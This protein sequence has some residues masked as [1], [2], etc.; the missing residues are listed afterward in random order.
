M[1]SF[2]K[3]YYRL[4]IIVGKIGLLNYPLFF[5]QEDKLSIELKELFKEWERRTSLALIPFYQER[6]KFMEEE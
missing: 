1:H 4:D 3:R 5:S 2:K 6:V